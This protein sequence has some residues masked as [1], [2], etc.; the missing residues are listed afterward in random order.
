MRVKS[1]CVNLCVLARKPRICVGCGRTIEEISRWEIASDAERL[2][3]LAALPDRLAA[4][5]RREA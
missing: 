2:V 3:I 4:L 1:P 5:E